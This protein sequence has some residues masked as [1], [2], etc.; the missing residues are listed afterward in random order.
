MALVLFLFRCILPLV[1]LEAL[2][3]VVTDKMLSAMVIVVGWLVIHFIFMALNRGE[4]EVLRQQEQKRL[5]ALREERVSY[6]YDP[7][8]GI[9]PWGNRKDD[10]G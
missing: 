5:Q 10:N 4:I 2:Y 1:L 6:P 9:Y 3:L 7:E 8:N